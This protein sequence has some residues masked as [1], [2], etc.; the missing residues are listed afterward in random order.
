MKKLTSLPSLVFGL[1]ST[2]A[3]STASGETL[4]E[5]FN[6][7]QQNDALLRSQEATY[8]ADKETENITRSPLLPQL[9]FNGNYSESEIDDN[10]F[11]ITRDGQSENYD[12]TLDQKLFDL[13]S[14]Y[15]HKQGKKITE[16]AEAQFVS[17]QQDLIVRVVQSYTDVLRAI[18]AYTTAKAEE[19]AIGRQLEQTKQRFEVGLIAITDVYESQASYDNALVNS[20]NA[21]GEIGIAFEA[22]E[23]LTGQPVNSIAPLVESF[24]VRD[25]DPYEREAWV[26]LAL[27]NNADLLVSML[28][29]DAALQNAQSKRAA[30]YPTLSGRY[31]YLDNDTDTTPPV[32]TDPDQ[33]GHVVSVNLNV[34]IYS[35][36]GT[37]ASRRQAWQ[38]H[39]AATELYQN[40]R[41]NTI[42]STR[43]FHLVV[44][45]DVAR[46]KALKQTIISTQ[47]ALDATKAG[48]DAGTRNIVDV[49]N[50]ER[51][52]YQAQ[53][54]W[55]N[56]RYQYITD[57][58]QL[59]K[60]AGTLLAEDIARFSTQTDGDNQYYRSQYE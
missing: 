53:R 33:E 25:P 45:T 15:A 18:D 57:F 4:L 16:Q 43:S 17:D 7:A 19:A 12:V 59:S 26:N 31:Q 49:L 42:Q 13:E 5:I 58:V 54:D 35:G 24:E 37:S 46:V 40:T 34:P 56:A 60:S 29:M 2:L 50:A 27:E 3:C 22:L 28:Q 55:L 39:T 36:G 51:A 11:G 10:R 44:T 41:R 9:S 20:L 23:T 21:Q 30:H 47:S 1:A 52:L 48:Y 8:L 38:Q 6:L 14:W 32:L